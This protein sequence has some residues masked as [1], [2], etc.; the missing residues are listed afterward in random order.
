MKKK[1]FNNESDLSDIIFNIWDNKIKIIIITTAFIILGLL[2]Y[3]NSSKNFKA[4]T[5]IKPISTFEDYKY[6]TY[7]T[8]VKKDLIKINR[9][10]LL[11]LFISKIQDEEIIKDGIIK[12][13]IIN[14]NDFQIKKNYDDQIQKTAI[15]II[16]NITPP[17][18]D[19]RNYQNSYPYWR[20][21]FEVK[22]KKKWLNFLEYLETRV[23][24]EIRLSLIKQFNLEL[25]MLKTISKFELE[26]IEEKIANELYNYKVSISNKLEF[27]REQAEIARTLNIAKNTLQTENFQTNNTIVTNIKSEESSSYYLKGYEMIEKEINLIS[28]RE[29]EKLFIPNLIELEQEKRKILQNREI[30]RLELL[31]SRTP[32]NNKNNF[33]AAKINYVA[34]NFMPKQSLSNI[35][36]IAFLIGLIISFIY[37]FFIKFITSRK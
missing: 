8:L 27:L 13:K 31:F 14:K 26:D 18:V 37:I 15:F 34:T 22:N 11:N 20:L 23:N 30:K 21:I 5:N 2:Y 36:T 19:E 28:S 12:S 17:L 10:N 33:K 29:N 32:V 6:K 9:E 16:D 24:D 1:P 25:E 3:Q 35:L 4:T 7:N